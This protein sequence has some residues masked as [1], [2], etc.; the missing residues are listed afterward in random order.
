LILAGGTS[1]ERE[2]SLRSGNSVR[3]A[4]EAAGHTTNL[5]DPAADGFDMAAAVAG[6][7]VVFSVLHGKGGEDGQTQAEL[8]KTGVSYVGTGTTASLLCFDKWKY[9]ETLLAEGLPVAQGEIVD[10][11]GFW[12]SALSKSAF[13]LKPIAGG[14]SIDT[15][16]VRD[17]GNMNDSAIRDTF[18]R[19]PQMLLEQL[20][21]GVEITIAVVGETSL[22]VIE[23][24]PPESGEFDYENKYNGA[25]QELCPP[26]HVKIA[27]QLEAQALAA[28]IHKLCDCRDYSRTDMIVETSGKL[29]VLETNTLP[30]MT[31]Q[32]LLPK[33]A[34]AAGISMTALCDRLVTM[35]L[36]RRT[37]HV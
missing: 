6:F 25:T 9:R 30:G 22:P 37:E 23:I 4:L 32:S 17:T 27:S 14:S 11:E 35:A 21:E 2:I 31:D 28:R 29:I 15:I 8:D 36:N 34:A 16:I 20:I 5:A 13:V 19:H 3:Q 7:D 24:I 18:E 26:Q 1:D 10:L 33:A 12:Q